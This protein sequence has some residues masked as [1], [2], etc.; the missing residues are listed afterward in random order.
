MVSS[1]EKKPLLIRRTNNN[2]VINGLV[3]EARSKM[4]SSTT[5]RLRG[6]ETLSPYAHIR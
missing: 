5:G 1:R 3:S 6:E 4:V 2:E